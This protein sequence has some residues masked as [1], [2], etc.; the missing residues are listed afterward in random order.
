MASYF[1]VLKKVL[2]LTLPDLAGKM[3][4]LPHGMLRLPTGKMSSR[5]GT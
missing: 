2:E 4:H 3:Q 5:T 1:A